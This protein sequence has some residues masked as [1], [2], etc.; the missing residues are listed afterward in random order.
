MAIAPSP[1]HACMWRVG[2]GTGGR[3]PRL[4]LAVVRPG[5]G[6]LRIDPHPGSRSLRHVGVPAATRGLVG[7]PGRSVPMTLMRLVPAPARAKLCRLAATDG[8]DALLRPGGPPW[9]SASR[10]CVARMDAPCAHRTRGTFSA[11]LPHHTTDGDIEA[12]ASSAFLHERQAPSGRSHSAPGQLRRE[13]TARGPEGHTRPDLPCR[14]G[15]PA[16]TGLFGQALWL[17]D[18]PI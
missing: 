6:S 2:D 13:A 14:T 1:P 11:R 4:S 3:G 12:N 5:C 8:R 15:V 10:S 16:S 17:A 9:V 18:E 7:S